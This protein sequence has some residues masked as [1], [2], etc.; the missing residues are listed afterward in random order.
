ME[1]VQLVPS[2]KIENS[3]PIL[4]L[5]DLPRDVEK[6]TA[7]REGRRIDDLAGRRQ[8]ELVRLIPG[9]LQDLAQRHKAIEEALLPGPRPAQSGSVSILNHFQRRAVQAIPQE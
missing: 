5:I 3:Q 9:G 8:N 7:P 1:T 2:Q 6:H 4:G